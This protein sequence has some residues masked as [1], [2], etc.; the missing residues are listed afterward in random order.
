MIGV[1]PEH[2]T[3]PDILGFELRP[4]RVPPDESL[5]GVDLK[6]PERYFLEHGEHLLVVEVVQEPDV[7]LVGVLL[8][9]DRVAVRHLHDA[10]VRLAWVRD[11]R[12]EEGADH[13]L[14]LRREV[15]TVEVVHDR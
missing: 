15:H 6:S 14:V 7:G 8:E 10:V 3:N 12:T 11:G 9:G 4:R 1:P 5:L 2:L 13:A